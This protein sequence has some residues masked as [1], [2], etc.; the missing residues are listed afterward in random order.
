MTLNADILGTL[1]MRIF[2]HGYPQI[3]I[4]E[5]LRCLHLRHPCSKPLR[6]TFLQLISVFPWD[7][8]LLVVPDPDAR[9]VH[10]G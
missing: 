10:G 3:K 6:I 8:K 7:L 9:Q 2:R 4:C 1:I 5:D